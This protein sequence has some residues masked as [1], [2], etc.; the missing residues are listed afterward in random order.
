MKFHL[1]ISVCM[2]PLL[3]LENIIKYADKII[4]LNLPIS[5][6]GMQEASE[7]LIPGA[8][9]L[10][11]STKTSILLSKEGIK[12]ADKLYLKTGIK[13]DAYIQNKVI[14]SVKDGYYE[15]KNFVYTPENVV[16]ITGG[17]EII[18]DIIND[19][20]PIPNTIKG[21]YGATIKNIY[22]ELNSEWKNTKYIFN[23]VI[24]NE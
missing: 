16:K 18:N 20:S 10:K 15:G 6:G 14:P 23:K 24:P 1:C 12:Q 7:I 8:P 2:F 3:L 4:G 21:T 19:G 11:T 13:T 17:I 22:D 5:T 9:I